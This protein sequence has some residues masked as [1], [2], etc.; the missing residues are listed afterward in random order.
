MESQKLN[1]TIKANTEN[2][3]KNNLQLQLDQANNA[4]T[5]ATEAQNILRTEAEQAKQAKIQSDH[6]AQQYANKINQLEEQLRRAQEE[7]RL[8]ED[9]EE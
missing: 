5:S 1:E 8:R 6:Q 9:T 4:L 2:Y 7:K 3:T